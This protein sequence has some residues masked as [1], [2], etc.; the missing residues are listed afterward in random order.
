MTK[1]NK[2]F[3]IA[4][5]VILGIAVIIISF[6]PYLLTQFT[7]D[8]WKVDFSDTGEIGDTIGGIM[9]PFIAIIAAMLTFLAFWIQYEANSKH[10]EQFDVQSKQ[11]QIDRFE[12]KFFEMV[13]LHRENVSDIRRY[14]KKE[15]GSGIFYSLMKEFKLVYQWTEEYLNTYKD[16]N[17][18]DFEEE[19][20]E[21]EEIEI[22]EKIKDL[23]DEDVLNIA[24]KTFFVGINET[25]IATL[26]EQLVKYDKVIVNHYLKHI[27]EEKIEFDSF[28]EEKE[29]SIPIL[30]GHLNDLA[31]YFRHLYQTVKLINE[32]PQKLLSDKSKYE[33]IRILRSQLSDYEQLLLLVNVHSDYGIKWIQ[34]RYL[35]YWKIVKNAPKEQITNLQLEVDD[36][37]TPFNCEVSS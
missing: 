10:V 34:E 21:E 12:S 17:I 32:V 22:A 20:I 1:K 23:K 6:L 2:D 8:S 14:Y 37:F 4:L 5:G 28:E 33:Y 36:Y 26:K 15:I 27:S 24:Y 9:G 25:S 31:H 30:E 7:V 11:N 18:E 29:E 3:L 19:E 13:K 35:S 16:F